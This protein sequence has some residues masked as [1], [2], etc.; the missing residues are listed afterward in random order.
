MYYEINRQML[1][2]CYISVLSEAS[3]NQN[4]LLYCRRLTLHVKG[5]IAASFRHTMRQCSC[6]SHWNWGH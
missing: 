6:I 1:F 3:L 2:L 5:P 4:L